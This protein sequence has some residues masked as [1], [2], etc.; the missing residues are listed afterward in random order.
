MANI[1][2]DCVYCD[3]TSEEPYAVFRARVR[4]CFAGLGWVCIDADDEADF[5]TNGRWEV[6]ASPG[7]IIIGPPFHTVV[8]LELPS[9]A[10]R[11]RF[12]AVPGEEGEEV[13]LRRA[14]CAQTAVDLIM[15]LDRHDVIR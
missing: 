10:H 6:Y 13:I 11:R 12:A 3:P 2:L 9:A 15:E 1:D 5:F 7:D 4:E 8:L 14:C